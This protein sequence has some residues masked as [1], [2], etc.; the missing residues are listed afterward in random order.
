MRKRFLYLIV[1]LLIFSSSSSIFADEIPQASAI[2]ALTSAPSL[3]SLEAFGTP[4]P[5]SILEDALAYMPDIES[6]LN[7]Q[8]K[9]LK[10]EKKNLPMPGVPPVDPSYAAF[11]AWPVLGRVTSGYGVRNNGEMQRVHEG[12]DIPVPKD[13][14]IQAAAAGVVAEA[15][16]FNGYGNTVI[17]DH[18]NGTKTLYAHC[19]AYA[20]KKGESVGSGQIIAY[21]GSTGRA[22]T[23]HL[24]FGVMVKGAFRDPMAYLKEKPQQFVNKP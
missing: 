10:N 1:L 4:K 21:A 2:P 14:P 17:I 9:D 6:W 23:S 8:K 5:P 11:L 22:T 12:I 13:T 16:A 18:K 15:R 7:D 3:P 19:S 24:H 20:V